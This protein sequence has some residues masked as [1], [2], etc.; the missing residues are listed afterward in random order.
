MRILSVALFLAAGSVIAG[1]RVGEVEYLSYEN[2]AVEIHNGDICV[3]GVPQIG[4]IIHYGFVGRKP[5][6]DEDG[7]FARSNSGG[8]K[9]WPE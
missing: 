2:D 1:V 9:I 5:K 6:V 3:L 4:R 7:L 8:D